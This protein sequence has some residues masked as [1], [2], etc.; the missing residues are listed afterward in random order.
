MNILRMNLTR[1]RRWRQVVMAVRLLVIIGAVATCVL[2][3]LS[4][5]LVN[6]PSALC[7]E[8]EEITELELDS[9]HVGDYS[10]DWVSELISG[11]HIKPPLIVWFSRASDVLLVLSA[12][13][14]GQVTFRSPPTSA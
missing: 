8:T 14:P 3:P 4:S 10:P 5:S 9:Q 6:D 11:T 13:S 12:G 2:A 7:I 1:K